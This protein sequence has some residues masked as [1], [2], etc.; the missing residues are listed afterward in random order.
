MRPSDG[1]HPIATA[2]RGA[3][4]WRSSESPNRRLARATPGNPAP[5][6]PI[7]VVVPKVDVDGV[8]GVRIRS[9]ELP[10]GEAHAVDVLGFPAEPGGVGVREDEHTMVPIDHAA[11]ASDVA[12]DARVTRGVH[13]P[14]HD[15]VSGLELRRNG[16]VKVGATSVPEEPSDIP[17]SEGAG[18]RLDDTRRCV[19]PT[20]A[21][22]PVRVRPGEKSV[23]FEQVLEPPKRALVV[24][25]RQVLG[26]RH[27]LAGE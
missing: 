7:Q 22:P 25:G 10:S 8:A 20:V 5:S 24:A 21:R 3:G 1:N 2:R 4:P 19:T 9:P 6:G 26:G 17:A 27:L 23:T 13:V 16:I 15:G 11:P 12:W 18:L 14:R